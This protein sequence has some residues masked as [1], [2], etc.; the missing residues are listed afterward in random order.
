M[1]VEGNVVY[2]LCGMVALVSAFATVT[3]RRPIRAALSL[4]VHIAALA[5]LFLTL[6]AHMLA[7]VQLI[8]YAGAVVVLFVFVIMYIGTVPEAEQPPAVTPSRV[9]SVASVVLLS[10]V[11]VAVVARLPAREWV[12]IA[13]CGPGDSAD[14]GQFGGVQALSRA[15]FRDAVVP[16]E[17]V[18]VLLTVA[19]VGAIMVARNPGKP[20]DK[21][22]TG[23]DQA[24][25]GSTGNGEA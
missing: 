3:V 8:V 13:V 17:L 4:L 7:F 16:F 9:F 10:V 23:N 6:H 18:G 2:L 1:S 5:G 14:C 19:V 24:L 25:T 22:E 12:G 20:A 15:L 11:T 21:A